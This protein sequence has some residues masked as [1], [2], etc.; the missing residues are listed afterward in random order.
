MASPRYIVSYFHF[1]CLAGLAAGPQRDVA[2]QLEVSQSFIAYWQ[3][4]VT[5]ETFHPESHGGARNI[6]YT[7]EE[8]QH[9]HLILWARCKQKPDTNLL[10]YQQLLASHSFL[11]SKTTL[12]RIFKSWHWSFKM[13]GVDQLNKYTPQNIA[14]YVGYVQ[15]VAE[16]P[17]G[18]LKYIDE[19]HFSSKGT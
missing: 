1:R 11:L 19:S 17:W 6:K 10:E 18:K 15:E 13:A 9:I 16:I 7:R 12:S 3:R 5:D 4:K 8:Y 2:A 14:Y